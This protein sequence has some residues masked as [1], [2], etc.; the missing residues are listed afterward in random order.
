MG[1]VWI[2]LWYEV[3][4]FNLDKNGRLYERR[5][6]QS[7]MSIFPSSNN[8]IVTYGSFRGIALCM[9]YCYNAIK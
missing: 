9:E 2:R 7:G 6:V 3:Y 4:G 5:D 1:S 8:K